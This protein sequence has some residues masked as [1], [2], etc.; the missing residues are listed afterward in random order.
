MCPGAPSPAQGVSVTVRSSRWWTWSFTV[1]LS[2]T[3][4]FLWPLPLKWHTEWPALSW[5]LP[6]VSDTPLPTMSPAQTKV[7]TGACVSLSKPEQHRFNLVSHPH[8]RP[9][10]SRR[11]GPRTAPGPVWLRAS[12]RRHDQRPAKGSPWVP[13]ATRPSSPSRR[14][15]RSFLRVRH[16][17]RPSLL[18]S[19]FSQS[20]WAVK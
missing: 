16:R 15:A 10:K 7:N 14:A 2:W 20:P 9:L 8:Q 1:T 3:T 6:R 19:P 4:T 18:G 5:T 13:T 17:A 11:A 12:A